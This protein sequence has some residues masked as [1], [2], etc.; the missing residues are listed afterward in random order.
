V[1]CPFLGSTALYGK[2]GSHDLWPDFY[3]L[4]FSVVVKA[5]RAP[6]RFR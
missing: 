6:G 3:N 2:A 1:K 5:S 4:F